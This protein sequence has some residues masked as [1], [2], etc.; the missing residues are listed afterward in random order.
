MKFGYFFLGL[1]AMLLTAACH[2]ENLPD[3][4]EVTQIAKEAYI[5]GYPTIGLYGDMYVRAID[6][7]GPRFLKPFNELAWRS[8][9]DPV[10]V[11]KAE[12][13][14]NKD[15]EPLP[16][17]EP[18]QAIRPGGAQ[19]GM[20]YGSVWFDLKNEPCVLLVPGTLAG[21][22]FSIQFVDLFSDTFDYISNRRDGNR[23]GRYLIAS[24]SWK[25]QKP[26]GIDRSIKSRSSYVLGLFRIRIES[27]DDLKNVEK[28][29]S[30]FS[31][32]PLSQY[33]GTT[34]QE[35]MAV[36]AY[37]AF[38]P[39]KAKTPEYFAYL[40]FMLQFCSVP[41]EESDLMKR[42]ARI[43]IEPG[44]PFDYASLSETRKKAL[45]DGM[46]A[47]QTELEALARSDSGKLNPV[48]KAE[49]KTEENYPY[50]AYMADRYLFGQS[51]EEML[52]IVY[53]ME[54]GQKKLDG[55]NR[56]EL[57][58]EK[59]QLPPVDA[60]WTVTVYSSGKQP[61]FKPNSAYILNSAS[62]ILQL[63]GDGSLLIPLQQ[64]MPE[65]VKRTNWLPVPSGPF[66]VLLQLYQ[67][68][69][70]ALKGSWS[71]P[72]LRNPDGSEAE[73]HALPSVAYPKP[74]E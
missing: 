73:N 42:F 43:G 16:D 20:A 10:T 68:R 52:A 55:R 12:T 1:M 74:E 23:G 56:Y 50:R 25:G 30:R 47:G 69:E 8:I 60:F 3:E 26:S 6:R 53:E 59:N 37:P 28:L 51:S 17:T 33:M 11:H 5:Y 54:T 31:I 57:R 21:R 22:Y 29:M 40:N 72:Q 48:Y 24:S 41:Q 65:P 44:K 36:I 70:E 45:I 66:F 4:A 32:V 15:E 63:N 18:V 49:E 13:V 2:Q 38:S 62:Q 61:S 7:E 64:E 27:S 39:E 67:P 9:Y 71:P 19:S 14:G 35:E 46:A 34:R 58:F